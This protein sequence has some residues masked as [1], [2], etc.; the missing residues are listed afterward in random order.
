MTTRGFKEA[1]FR[2][3]AEWISRIAYNIDCETTRKEVAEEVK[4]VM[5]RING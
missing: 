4:E 2:K 5:T 3:V 1:E